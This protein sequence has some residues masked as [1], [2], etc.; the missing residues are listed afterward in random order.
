[1][2][3]RIPIA[4]RVGVPGW[5]IPQNHHDGPIAARASDFLLS[6]Q[7]SRA[8]ETATRS[9]SAV[10]S[11]RPI[12]GSLRRA[13]LPIQPAM[14]YFSYWSDGP[15]VAQN[16][17]DFLAQPPR[18]CQRCGQIIRVKRVGQATR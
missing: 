2:P 6:A 17:N 18:D 16:I 9:S 12:H 11:N 4:A 5:M 8:T 15:C 10:E 1:M 13:G 14:S 7:D 3:P